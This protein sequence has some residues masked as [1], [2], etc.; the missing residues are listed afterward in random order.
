MSDDL[1]IPFLGNTK[2]ILLIFGMCLILF[3]VFFVW[4]RWFRLGKIGWKRVDYIWLLLALSGVISYTAQSRSLLA[5][6]LLSLAGDRLEGGYT[7]LKGYVEMYDGSPAICRK[8]VTT[9]YSPPEP[10][11]NRIQREYDEACVWFNRLA[12]AIPALRKENPAE[13]AWSALPSPPAFS[14]RALIEN[15]R[16]VRDA[17]G[18]F[19]SRLAA[20]QQLQSETKRYPSEETLTILAPL[21]LAVALALRITK[22]TGEIGIERG[23]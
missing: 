5:K 11:F 18:E 9:E 8:F 17:V 19:N 20:Y 21:L 23:R 3:H 6:N 4:L 12:K 16:T 7:I 1:T 22:V 13:I 14:E 10:E 2:T 15:V